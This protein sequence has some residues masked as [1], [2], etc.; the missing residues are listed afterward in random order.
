MSRV[1]KAPVALPKGV[2]AKVNGSAFEC[3]GPKG[4][5]SV[6][7]AAGIKVAVEDNSVVVS[8]DADNKLARAMHGTMRALIQNNVLGVAEGYTKKL[9]I[10]GVGYRVV[11]QGKKLVFNIGFCHTVE[12]EAPEGIN[13]ACPDQ[14]HVDVTGINKQAVGQI[15]AEIRAIRKPEPYKGKGIRYVGEYVRRKAGKSAKK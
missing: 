12:V 4:S 15:A 3:K 7:I 6:D 8:R 10:Q 9:E 14:T 1:G 11:L 13:F 2:E 5:L